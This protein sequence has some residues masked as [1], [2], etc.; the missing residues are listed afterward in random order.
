MAR[1]GFILVAGNGFLEIEKGTGHGCGRG[2]VDGIDFVGKRGESDGKKLFRVV[3][4][5]LVALELLVEELGEE[6]LFFS[7]WRSIEES[8]E[9]NQQARLNCFFLRRR[10]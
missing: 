2:K 3:G 5:G 9:G 10:D 6:R 1:S 4:C 7:A 8:L